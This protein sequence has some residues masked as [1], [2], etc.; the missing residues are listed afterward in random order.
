M[1]KIKILHG[2]NLNLLGKREPHIYGSKTLAQLNNTCIELGKSIGAQVDCEQ[3]NSEGALI[4]SIHKAMSSHHALI[5]NPGAYAH[6]SIALRDAL[7]ACSIPVYEVHISNIFK[8]E[9]FRHRSYLSS[10]AV[11]VITGLGAKGYELALL[12][13]VEDLIQN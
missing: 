9:E 5:I 4:E 10:V 11:G 1:K 8:R 7:L 3:H 2:P 6:T 12:A 13:A